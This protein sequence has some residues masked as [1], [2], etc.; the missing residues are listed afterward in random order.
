MA[1]TK[2]DSSR[3][4][5]VVTMLAGFAGAGE[6]AIARAQP[7]LP[8]PGVVP[9]QPGLALLPQQQLAAKPG[10]EAV[11]PCRLEQQPAGGGIAGLGDATAFD[12]ATARVFRRH[13]PEIGYQLVCI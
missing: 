5:A 6:P 12:A 13:Q 7:Q 11:A 8:L 1:H 10:R 2:P 4:I 3:A 9:D